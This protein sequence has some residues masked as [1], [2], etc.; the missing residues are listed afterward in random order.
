MTPIA[1]IALDLTYTDTKVWARV[2]APARTASEDEWS[3]AFKITEPFAIE[4]TIYGASS[5]Q[6][7]V[8][9]LKALSSYLYGSEA[10][11]TKQLGIGGEFGGNLSFPAPSILH[12]TAPF[13]F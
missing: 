11:Q 2:Y 7:L 5:L 6:A 4:R 8:L 1:E 13:P 12:D 9:A 3:C 10:Y